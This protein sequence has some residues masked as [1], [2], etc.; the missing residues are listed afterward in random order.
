MLSLRGRW[1]SLEVATG[2]IGEVCSMLS[3]LVHFRRRWGFSS[4]V[5]FI[6]PQDGVAILAV[7]NFGKI[8]MDCHRAIGD[9]LQICICQLIVWTPLCSFSVLILQDST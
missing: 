4:T 5:E 7:S 6:R 8:E 9:I 2:C 1:F 3:E